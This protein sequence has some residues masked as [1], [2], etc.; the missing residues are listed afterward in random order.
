MESRR[1]ITSKILVIIVKAFFGSLEVNF[2]NNGCNRYRKITPPKPKRND[3]D[4][5][6]RAW[7]FIL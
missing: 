7:K 3:G 1:T 2:S 4:K 5:A 6:I